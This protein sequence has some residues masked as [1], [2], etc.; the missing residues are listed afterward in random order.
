M[1]GGNPAK[2]LPIRQWRLATTLA[3]I[4][5]TLL[6]LAMLWPVTH[7]SFVSDDYNYLSMLSEWQGMPVWEKLMRM[8]NSG[9][10]A[11]LQNVQYLSFYRAFG[12]NAQYWYLMLISAHCVNALLVALVG[13]LLTGRRLVAVLS[14]L[15]FGVSAAFWQANTIIVY[16]SI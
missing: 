16:G 11:L 12:L 2:A 6:V 5:I 10:F 9:H 3:L 15:V 7:N 14:A 13:F 8:S 1:Y 4:A